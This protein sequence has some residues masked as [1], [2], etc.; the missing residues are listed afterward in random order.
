M[1]QVNVSQEFFE[2]ISNWILHYISDF[3][4]LSI[5]QKIICSS[6]SVK[7]E[8]I[9]Y[10]YVPNKKNVHVIENGVNITL[11]LPFIRTSPD[12][13]TAYNIAGKGIADSSSFEA[14]IKSAINLIKYK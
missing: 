8:A 11:G 12:H 13:G 5:A 14:A 4:G 7:E 6:K 3:I 10:Y 1:P 9:K 2:R